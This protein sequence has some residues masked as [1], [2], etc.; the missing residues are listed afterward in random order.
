MAIAKAAAERI[1]KEREEQESSDEMYKQVLK[2]EEDLLVKQKELQRQQQE[3]NLIIS[4]ASARLQQALKNKDCI[5]IDRATILIDGGNNRS[6]IIGDELFK[7][8]EDL[9]NIQKKR[10]DTF[11]KQ[12][13]QKK[14]RITVDLNSN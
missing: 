8:T 6:K 13:Q 10:K 9:M 14:Q 5:N 12:Q 7:V 3:V 2:Q 4:D 11:A 1:E